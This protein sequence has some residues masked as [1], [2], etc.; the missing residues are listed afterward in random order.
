MLHHHYLLQA[1][2]Y[3]LALHRHLRATMTGYR[4]EDHLGGSAYLFVR[5]FPNQGTWF[6]RTS[7]TSLARLDALFAEAVS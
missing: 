5:G 6:E 2:F 4:P 7:T 1:R 3:M